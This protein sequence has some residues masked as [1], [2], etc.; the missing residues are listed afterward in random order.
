[1][2]S[3]AYGT[4]SVGGTYRTGYN[5]S[6]AQ[7]GRL[8]VPIASH[9]KTPVST[10]SLQRFARGTVYRVQRSTGV[11]YYLYGKVEDKYVAMG[12]ATST[13]GAPR[14]NMARLSSGAYRAYFAKGSIVQH[15]N[16]AVRV[17]YS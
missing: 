4:F 17:Y 8:G 12:E 16:G 2:Y 14:S 13:L 5:A 1:M 9:E 15:S 6:G 10:V 7:G 3:T 11:P